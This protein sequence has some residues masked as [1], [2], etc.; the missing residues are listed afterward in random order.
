MMSVDQPVESLARETEVLGESLP[1]FRFVHHKSHMTFPGL[2]SG[3][4]R[5]EAG[6]RNSVLSIYL[7][8]NMEFFFFPF[9]GEVKHL[10]CWPIVPAPDD[11]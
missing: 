11:G 5:W 2:Q 4:P 8:G 3:P 6:S 1:Q 7:F 10:H 9:S